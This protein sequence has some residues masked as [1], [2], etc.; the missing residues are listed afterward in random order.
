MSTNDEEIEWAD[1]PTPEALTGSPPH[2]VGNGELGAILVNMCA[3]L[4]TA[5]ILLGESDEEEFRVLSNRLG[6]FFAL[7]GQLQSIRPRQRRAV[8]FKTK[9]PKRPAAS[10]RPASRRKRKA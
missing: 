10:K 5:I 4:T 2:D 3:Q 6:A 8:G 7:A 9:S 1:E